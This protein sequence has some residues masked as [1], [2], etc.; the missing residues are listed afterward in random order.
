MAEKTAALK[1]AGL[2]GEDARGLL[3]GPVTECADVPDQALKDG[4]TADAAIAALS[5]S[6][7][8]SFFLAV[9]FSKPHLSFIAPEKVLGSV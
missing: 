8:K 1:K 3:S 6:K 7:D 4:V 9:G 2:A 5:G